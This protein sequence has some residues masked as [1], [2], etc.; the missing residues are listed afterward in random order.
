MKILE[1]R[2]PALRILAVINGKYGERIVANLRA[3]VLDWEVAEWRAPTWYPLVIDDP[4]DFLPAQLDPADLILALGEQPGMVEL[5][6][7][8]CE[9]TGATAVIAP[10]DNNA[11]LPKGLS[12]QLRGWLEEKGVTCVLPKPFCSLTETTYSLRGQRVE[13]DNPLIAE[14]ARRFGKPRFTVHVEDKKIAGVDIERASPC[15]CSEFVA[16]GLAAV[17]VDDA[18]FGAGMLHHHYPCWASMQIDPDYSDTLM[19]VSGQLTVD[20]ISTAVK[21]HKQTTYLKPK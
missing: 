15:G 2:I 5:L 14:F 17:K 11:W 9:M 8:L 6:P 13:Y 19:H 4:R 10:I 20:A 3:A 12:N 7:D 1:A 21:P 18:E 16:N